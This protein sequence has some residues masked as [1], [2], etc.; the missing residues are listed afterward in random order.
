[1]TVH[2]SAEAAQFGVD[3]TCSSVNAMPM[4]TPSRDFMYTA[5]HEVGVYLSEKFPGDQRIRANGAAMTDRDWFTALDAAMLACA[6]EG[7]SE[8][9]LLD[10]YKDILIRK[11]TKQST[12]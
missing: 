1:M 3:A 7:D 4:A 2:L 9:L 12:D 10:V 11:L 8:K 5:A 6:L